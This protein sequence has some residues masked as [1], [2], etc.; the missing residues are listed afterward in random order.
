MQQGHPFL[1]VN[2]NPKLS[3]KLLPPMSV[4]PPLVG[5]YVNVLV[6]IYAVYSVSEINVHRLIK[7]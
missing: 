6:A 1:F 7:G 2:D 3:A 4:S 5:R